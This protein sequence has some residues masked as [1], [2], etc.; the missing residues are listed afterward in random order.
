MKFFSPKSEKAQK[1]N[2]PRIGSA[3]G[4]A[5]TGSGS[6]TEKDKSSGSAGGNNTKRRLRGRPPLPTSSSSEDEYD[7]QKPLRKSVHHHRMTTSAGTHHRRNSKDLLEYKSNTNPRNSSKKSSP[8]N[9]MSTKQRH[10]SSENILEKSPTVQPMK[11][12]KKS[13]HSEGEIL[14]DSA[15]NGNKKREN[16]DFTSNRKSQQ[17][18]PKISTVE[19]QKESSDQNTG[20]DKSHEPFGSTEFPTLKRNFKLTPA[21]TPAP[22]AAGALENEYESMTSIRQ[23]VWT[24]TEN[25]SSSKTVDGLSSPSVI[26]QDNSAKDEETIEPPP[27]FQ[28]EKPPPLPVKKYAIKPNRH[29]AQFQATLQKS[30]KLSP[31]LDLDSAT[32]KKSDD[33][34]VLN[35]NQVRMASLQGQAEREAKQRHARNKRIRNRSLEMVLDENRSSDSSPS[36]RRLTFSLFSQERKHYLKRKMFRAAH[37]DSSTRD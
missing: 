28:E 16:F 35:P 5:G 30:A 22:P 15:S 8:K 34:M 32:K 10:K 20:S 13:S 37:A 25:Q 1:E 17:Q 7:L 21:S 26:V 23:N 33:P 12:S 18:I 27:N 14:E 31:K 3:S 6:G 9:L 11:P 4:T 36:R 2:S 29:E 24:P 19:T